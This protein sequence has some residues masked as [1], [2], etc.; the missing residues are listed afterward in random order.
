MVRRGK[1]LPLNLVEPSILVE[2]RG[3]YAA[4]VRTEDAQLTAIDPFDQGVDLH[5][6]AFGQRLYRMVE[7]RTFCQAAIGDFS[8]CYLEHAVVLTGRMDMRFDRSFIG[9]PVGLGLD[10]RFGRKSDREGIVGI[11]VFL[12]VLR[13][14]PP[15]NTA[16]MKAIGR[17]S[18]SP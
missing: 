15:M 16:R 4:A 7:D 8:D 17:I 11:P 14:S 1:R 2:H 12:P 3:R 10:L 5:L 18:S 13:G 9:D 6:A